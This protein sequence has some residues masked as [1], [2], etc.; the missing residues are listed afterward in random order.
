MH[1][2]HYIIYIVCLLH[3]S[4]T[5]VAIIRG[6]HYKGYVTKV[7]EPVHKCKILKYMVE[8]IY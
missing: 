6:V 2:L 5:L 3:V 8:N 4:V 1:I 7:F